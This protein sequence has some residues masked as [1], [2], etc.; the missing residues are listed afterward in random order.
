MAGETNFSDVQGISKRVYDKSGLK[1]IQFGNTWFQGKVLFDKGTTKLGDTYQVGVVTQP[2]NGFTFP[3]SS[4][5][6]ATL[7]QARAMK[8]E[9]ASVRGHEMILREQFAWAA[10][11]RAAAEGEGAFAALTGEAYKAMKKAA[12]NRVEIQLIHGQD[13]EG[14][15]VIETTTDLTGG[16]AEIVFTE[17]SFAPG[18]FHA[19][20]KGATFDA[21]TSTTKNNASGPL[22]LYSI[23]SRNRKIVVQFTGT[24]AS[25]MAIG[26]ILRM[27]GAYDGTTFK[28]P[29]GLLKQYGNTSGDS[30]GI[31]ATTSPGWAGN[32]FNVN[33]EITSDK[34][35][36]MFADL[37]DRG[38]DG[39][40]WL[41]VST[42]GFSKLMSEPRAMRTLDSSYSPEKVKLGHKSIELET[43]EFGPVG[44]YGHPF[45]KR[46]Q[47]L[48]FAAEDTCRVGSSDIKFGLPDAED[49]PTWERVPNSTA[50]EV[51]LYSDQAPLVKMPKN[52]LVGSGITFAS[53]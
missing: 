9:Q 46:G 50:A 42:K 36:E 51:I 41:V 44:V 21:W 33:G 49:A 6:V 30:M 29:A 45:F 37:R 31:N 27:E 1:T 34:A 52:G 26:D 47:S 23:D 32:T 2:P 28:E 14:L 13:P 38:A 25:E 35:E 48:T 4:G 11:S 15:G 22:V 16:L 17:A 3:G 53:T 8:I 19:M 10:L 12:Q 7:L 18:L 20:S 24:H 40:L 43:D 39:R 5:A